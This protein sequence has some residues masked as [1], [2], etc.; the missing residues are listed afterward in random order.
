MLALSTA[1]E[2]SMQEGSQTQPSRHFSSRKWM[3]N[4]EIGVRKGSEYAEL[5]ERLAVSSSKGMRFSH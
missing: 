3:A 1:G 5:V 2:I 4:S